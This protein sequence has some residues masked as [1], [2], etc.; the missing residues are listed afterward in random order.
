MESSFGDVQ[1]AVRDTASTLAKQYLAPDA[2]RLD[3]GQ[4]ELHQVL[5]TVL[6]GYSP[7]L[8][9]LIEH[10]RMRIPYRS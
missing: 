4:A 5:N 3:R 9:Q 10:L 7:C 6:R 2:A 8:E 1:L